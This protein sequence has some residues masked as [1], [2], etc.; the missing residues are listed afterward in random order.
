M[1]SVQPFKDQLA[2]DPCV[3]LRGIKTTVSNFIR[4]LATVAASPP[5]KTESL[6]LPVY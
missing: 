2:L 4:S 3:A 1:N 6:R 5:H